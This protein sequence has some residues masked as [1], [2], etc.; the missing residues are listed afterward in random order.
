MEID[1]LLV[2]QLLYFTGQIC[3]MF[4]SIYELCEVNKSKNRWVEKYILIIS[5]IVIYFFYDTWWKIFLN[6]LVCVLVCCVH[7]NIHMNISKGIFLLCYPVLHTGFSVLL[8]NLIDFDRSLLFEI[9]CS[10][11]L[12]LLE[13]LIVYFMLI[14]L[15][16]MENDATQDKINNKNEKIFEETIRHDLNNH[17]ST[18]ACLAHEK[19]NNDISDYI[20]KMS[21]IDYSV[22]SSITGNNQMDI[23][24]ANKIDEALKKGITVRHEIEVPSDLEVDAFDMTVLLGNAFDNAIS[25]VE[26]LDNEYRFIDFKIIYKR[27]RLFIIMKNPCFEKGTGLK[28]M[29][30]IVAHYH[31]VMELDFENIMAILTIFLYF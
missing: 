20:K 24:L 7:F 16:K 9:V 10:F 11:L 13:F 3:I 1:F 25:A 21:F 12:L 2:I 19:K 26:N 30:M 27:N 6:I 22:I 4:W 14:I 31:G 5:I 15:K 28:N 29:E 23:I 18:I 17:L 8:V